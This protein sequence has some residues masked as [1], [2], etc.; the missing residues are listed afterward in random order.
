LHNL[1]AYFVKDDH[2][3]N[4]LPISEF[5]FKDKDFTSATAYS[6]IDI[7]TMFWQIKHHD[8]GYALAHAMQI[9]LDTLPKEIKLLRI[10]TSQGYSILAKPN[11]FAIAEIQVLPKQP[12]YINQTTKPPGL[13]ASQVSISEYVTGA[14]GI[15][16]GCTCSLAINQFGVQ[17]QN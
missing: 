3:K 17:I 11:E 15:C 13:K 10:R 12:F 2:K 9:V 4:S 6:D 7:E 5:D 14:D 8:H 1:R 16:P